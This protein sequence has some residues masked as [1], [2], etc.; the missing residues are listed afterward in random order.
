MASQPKGDRRQ[1][2]REPEPK[3][4]PVK[5]AAAKKTETKKESR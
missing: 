3:E 2:Y 4:R 1:R 5:K